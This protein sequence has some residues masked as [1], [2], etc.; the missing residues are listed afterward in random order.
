MAKYVMHDEA[1]WRVLA[2]TTLDDEPAYELTRR[3]LQKTGNGLKQSAF[4]ITARVRECG[5]DQ[6]ERTR[7]WRNAEA[8][9][10]VEDL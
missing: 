2:D 1:R 10:K 8:K 4:T 6:H 3:I 9:L 5:P 7:T